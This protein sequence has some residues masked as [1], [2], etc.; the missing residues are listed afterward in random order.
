[1]KIHQACLSIDEE[2]LDES[3]SV[4]FEVSDL[5]SLN[6]LVMTDQRQRVHCTE[7]Y[8]ILPDQEVPPVPLTALHQSE[9]HHL[10]GVFEREGSEK[11]SL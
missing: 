4:L 8:G 7:L 5:D 3:S 9:V 10:D 6:S 1:M 11:F 2:E